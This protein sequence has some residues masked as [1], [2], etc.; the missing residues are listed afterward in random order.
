MKKIFTILF[1]LLALNALSVNRIVLVMNNSFN[2]A[3]LIIH[4]GD[5]ITWI[6][7]EGVHSVSSTQI[8]TSAEP[9][10]KMLDNTGATFV[11]VPQVSGEY[12]YQCDIHVV[13]GMTG[14]FIVAN[15]ITDHTMSSGDIKLQS[16]RVTNYL[17]FETEANVTAGI[18]IRDLTGKTVKRFPAA[19]LCDVNLY[20]GDL[21]NGVYILELMLNNE[22]KNFRFIKWSGE[23]TSL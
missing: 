21:Q 6:L 1:V 5:T 14:R 2:P 12:N 4:K 22:S 23:T 9:W 19:L 13:A 11:Y 15:Q 7:N 18:S 10:S 20:V 16:E 17:T 3:S 8:P